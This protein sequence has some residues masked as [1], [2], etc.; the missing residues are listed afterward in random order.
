[1]FF[2]HLRIL[3]TK[4]MYKI[5]RI[6]LSGFL[7]TAIII[8]AIKSDIAAL[9]KFYSSLYTGLQFTN[10]TIPKT[11]TSRRAIAN[12]DTIP[13]TDTA[14]IHD[15]IAPQK[16]DSFTL[17]LSKDTLDAPVKYTASD[18]AVGLLAE[19]LITLYGKAKAE[20]QDM[21]LSAPFIQLNQG[22]NIVI[23]RAGR[24]S[25][26]AITD[27]AEMKQGENQFKSDSMQYNFK[28]KQG[29]TRGTIT[30]QSEMFIHADIVKKVDERTL[31]G[32]GAF[33]TTCNLDE[34]HFGFR[35]NRAKIM[36]QKLAVTGAVRPEFDSVPVPIYL[37][38]GIYPLS[39]GRHSGVIAPSFETNDQ[40]GLG[41]AGLG[42]YH[43]VNDY[44]D[45][46]VYGNIYS[47]GSYSINVNPT[48]RKIYKYSGQFNFGLQR[49]KRNFKGD[50]DEFKSNTYTVSWSHGS[51]M[52]SRP[53]TSFSANV[54]ASSTKY[55]EN[56]PNSN[57]LNF[58]N[59]LG[60]SI[61]YSKNWQDK[62]FSLTVGANHNQ[63]NVSRTTSISL[64]NIGFNVNTIYPL[65][66][67][68]GAGAKKWY[69]QLGI[70]YQG[71]FRNNVSFIDTI[72]YKKVY[73]TSMFRHIL[74]TMQWGAQHSIPISLSLPP[75]LGGALVISPSISYS[76]E[77]VDRQIIREWV[78][79]M[80]VLNRD[81]TYRQVDT[82]L[83]RVH[84]GIGIRQQMS[85][86]IG[87]NTALYGTYQFKNKRL[88]AIRHVIRPN[89]GLSYSPDLNKNMWD[90]VQI[91]KEGTKRWFNRLD[92]F[93]GGGASGGQA[94]M[95]SRRF[96]GVNF[97]LD[98]NIEMKV[99]AKAK[100]DTTATADNNTENGI[101]KI[102]LIEG[103][104]F[105]SS[106]NL[107]ADSMKLAPFNFYFRTNLFEKINI[108]ASAM[109][110]PYVLNA[111][112]NPTKAYAW[113]KGK[114]GT[115]TNGSI[116]ASTSFQS[117]AKDPAKEKKRQ[118]QIN[119][120]LS[121]PMMQA[122]QQRLLEYMRQNPAEFVDFNTP[123]SVSLSYS[124]NFSRG[125]NSL[126]N[127]S[128]LNVYSSANFTG[129]F[130]LTPKWNFSVNGFYDFKT[131][132]IQTFAMAI[133]RD[134]HCW[135]M[136]INVTPVGIYRYFNFTIS[137]KAGI[138]QDLK[139]NR[140]RSFYTGH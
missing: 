34:P 37:P 71:S 116:S 64:P 129:S 78:P 3:Q 14:A 39:Q 104:G 105:T 57:L 41:L 16:V 110:T 38:F 83:A 137:P 80:K 74:D 125:Y 97:G 139:V 140:T 53:G 131:A 114:L 59:T 63:V 47:L 24:D 52:R 22:K 107:F 6:Y 42:Y 46:K 85:M 96:G 99:R 35:A 2:I 138:L 56:V 89:F 54:N 45:V 130:N 8:I 60:S 100:K 93:Y 102:R 95:V 55:N 135:Q 119:Q 21:S 128:G 79:G 106:Y 111:S 88:M 118:D 30:Q 86:G 36:N 28:S 113:S 90:P 44:W 7:I 73:G 58:Q 87:F 134:L 48:Y 5:N 11:D 13:K 103:L 1:M 50:P 17:K 62:P 18:S 27:Y 70:G 112:G 43:V 115:I 65:E 127:S 31:Y 33:F 19:K 76:Q 72:N 66:R 109:F 4:Q 92:G 77:W 68:E 123:W 26:G 120:N 25:T 49:T 132:K 9:N 32:K 108:N 126:L 91:D 12:K 121:D 98:N 124:L 82:V 29:L 84:K 67:K 61:T 15:T 40:M 136:A 51:D 117:K 122:D 20:Y 81:G 10:D 133:S 101:K 69:E 23:A 75:I 94:M